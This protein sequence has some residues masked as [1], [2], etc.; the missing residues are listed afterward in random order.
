M[1]NG[2][3]NA[4]WLRR[5]A[6]HPHRV[7]K[8]PVRP[9]WRRAREHSGRHL[10]TGFSQTHIAYHHHGPLGYQHRVVDRVQKWISGESFLFQSFTQ[11]VWTPIHC[12]RKFNPTFST[13]DPLD[14][15]KAEALGSRWRNVCVWHQRQVWFQRITGGIPLTSV[16]G[17][18]LQTAVPEG[19]TL[20]LS[21]LPLPSLSLSANLPLYLHFQTNHFISPSCQSQSPVY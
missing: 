20:R 3:P 19:W 21:S 15:Q 10:C 5:A 11:T 18:V 14:H 9:G 8:A 1:E 2:H 7:L 12:L 17:D 16:S 6:V 4:A 13:P